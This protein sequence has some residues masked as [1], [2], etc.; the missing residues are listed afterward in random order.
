METLDA[1]LV[2][3][4]TI[5]ARRR[6][7]GY[8]E[9]GG[10]CSRDVHRAAGTVQCGAE[11]IHHTRIGPHVNETARGGSQ[12]RPDKWKSASTPVV[13]DRMPPAPA[14]SAGVA[15]AEAPLSRLVDIVIE[16]PEMPALE[17]SRRLPLISTV[18]VTAEM[19]ASMQRVARARLEHHLAALGTDGAGL[20]QAAVFELAREDPDGIALQRSQV[21]GLVAG[22]LQF[23]ADA[24]QAAPGQFHLLACGQQA[25]RRRATAPGLGCRPAHPGRS[26]PRRRCGRESSRQR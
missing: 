17:T 8:R 23:H 20:D 19:G 22:R 21:D 4:Q 7:G 12:R 11:D 9:A 1:G 3:A 18:P 16:P 15:Q 10:G 6:H 14:A 2:T 26:A 5:S 25:W 24:F 13:P